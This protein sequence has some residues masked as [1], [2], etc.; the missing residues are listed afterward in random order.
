[1]SFPHVSEADPLSVPAELVQSELGSPLQSLPSGADI[2]GT[3][4]EL[5]L[6]TV[7]AGGF[8]S[9]FLFFTAVLCRFVL[10]FKQGCI[11]SVGVAVVHMMGKGGCICKDR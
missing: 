11:C 3:W 8:I 7:L 9:T 10:Y 4:L 6:D 2:R 1:M 5:S